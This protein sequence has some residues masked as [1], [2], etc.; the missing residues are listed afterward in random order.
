[1]FI[2]GQ[3]IGT[4]A[5]DALWAITGGAKRS[6]FYWASCADTVGCIEEIFRCDSGTCWTKCASCCSLTIH[7]ILDG[8]R[9]GSLAFTAIENAVGVIEPCIVLTCCSCDSTIIFICIFAGLGE[10]AGNY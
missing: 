7:A 2:G 6:I 10:G 1:M 5:S 4:S 3:L 8:A 9:I